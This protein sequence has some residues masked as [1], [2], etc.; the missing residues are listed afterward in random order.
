MLISNQTNSR[1]RPHPRT[2]FTPTKPKKGP[3]RHARRRIR[4]SRLGRYAVALAAGTTVAAALMVMSTAPAR[5]VGGFSA[6]GNGLALRAAP[7]TNAAVI[8][9]Y[10]NGQP[11]DIAC[12]T[13]GASVNGSSIWDEITGTGGYVSDYY[14][15]GTPYAQFDNRLPRCGQ[16]TAAASSSPTVLGG[17]DVTDYCGLIHGDPNA[18][19]Q[20]TNPRNAYSWQCA[21]EDLTRWILAGVPVPTKAQYIHPWLTAGVDMNNACWWQYNWNAHAVLGNPTNPYSWYCVR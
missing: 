16:A 12:Q 7:S 2:A 4:K 1:P 9:R 18:F 19:A 17:I 14:V 20:A 10:S 5:A 6:A 13:T 11:L 3:G 8:A 21:Y 15:N